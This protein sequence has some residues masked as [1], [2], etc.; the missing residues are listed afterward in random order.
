MVQVLRYQTMVLF[1]WRT[2]IIF[3]LMPVQLLISALVQSIKPKKIKYLCTRFNRIDNK[4][5]ILVTVFLLGSNYLFSQNYVP[6]LGESNEWY[7]FHPYVDGA[8]TFIYY[9]KGDT[10]LYGR[11]YKIIGKKGVGNTYGF[12]REDIIEQKVYLLG[13]P[14][15]DTTEMIW[16]DFSLEEN[17][18]ILLYDLNYKILGNY[19]VDSIRTINTLAGPRRAIYLMGLVWV[20]GV[21][22]LGSI[23]IHYSTPYDINGE[24]LNCFFRDGVKVFESDIAMDY[25][26]C[27]FGW[28]K[29]EDHPVKG[30]LRVYPN[31]ASDIATF[32]F[33]DP[34]QSDYILMIFN[35]TGQC[36]LKR[37]IS[38][39][40]RFQVDMS[41]KKPGIYYYLLTNVKNGERFGGKILKE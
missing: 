22:S 17:D 23:I 2:M 27:I 18:S 24:G 33:T 5:L 25:D 39:E 19:V 20:E 9:T 36:I 10:I 15:I 12:M 30:K 11:N 35:N 29:V 16:Y 37:K 32:E 14:A 3:L 28:S 4:I 8:E 41:A 38:G 26:S 13:N 6:M 1:S 7:T 31:P 21:G 34:E 40:D